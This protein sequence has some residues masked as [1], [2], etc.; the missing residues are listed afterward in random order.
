M[1]KQ[2][3]IEEMETVVCSSCNHEG[4]AKRCPKRISETLV[5]AGYGNVRQALTE[6]AEKVK[7]QIYGEELFDEDIWEIIDETLKEF[8]K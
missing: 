1:D 8:L 6:F 2:K 5:N 7:R 3:M 4:M